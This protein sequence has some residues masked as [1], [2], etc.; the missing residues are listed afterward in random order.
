ML[1]PIENFT[2]ENAADQQPANAL[3]EAVRQEMPPPRYNPEFYTLSR[4][5]QENLL[6][7]A[8]RTAERLDPQGSVADNTRAISESLRA[9]CRENGTS[10]LTTELFIDAV[11][12]QLGAANQGRPGNLPL[13][14]LTSSERDPISGRHNVSINFSP[15][16]FTSHRPAQELHIQLPR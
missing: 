14:R 4:A 9:V 5:Q 7:N 11:N 16:I 15:N 12:R 6:A 3:I 1:N 13:L 8:R 2:L 10:R